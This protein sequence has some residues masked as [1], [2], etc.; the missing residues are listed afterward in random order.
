MSWN[1]IK[2]RLFPM[3]LEERPESMGQKLRKE[4]SSE[5]IC[6]CTGIERKG[7]A[8]AA[9]VNRA[10]PSI[11]ELK[12]VFT[13]HIAD[14]TLVLCGGLHGYSSLEELAKCSVKDVTS[15]PE[16][17]FYNLNTV[18]GYHSSRNVATFIRVSL[19]SF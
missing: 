16:D 15:E 11:D 1:L 12:E 14:D 8:F 5:Y 7:A 9:S 18:N 2:E 13:G 17:R 19:P 10:R 3:E 6:I 4:I